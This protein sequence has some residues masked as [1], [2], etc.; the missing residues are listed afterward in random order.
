ML[1]LRFDDDFGSFSPLWA[2]L[3]AALTTALALAFAELAVALA[4]A[5]TLEAN[6]EAVCNRDLIL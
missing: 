6:D 5:L 1:F 4:V 2:I 3:V